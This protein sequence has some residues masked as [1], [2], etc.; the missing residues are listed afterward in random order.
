M[1]PEILA[2]H[3]TRGGMI[4][5][6]GD[7][8]RFYIKGPRAWHMDTNP[9]AYTARKLRGAIGPDTAEISA[10]LQRLGFH[11]EDLGEGRMAWHLSR[12]RAYWRVTD[13]HGGLPSHWDAATM[14]RTGAGSFEH[15]TCFGSTR[16]CIDAIAA[17]LADFDGPSRDRGNA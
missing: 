6:L 15:L 5:G 11:R 14:W 3:V 10:T 12:G 13:D 2:Q 4:W 7:D 1:K 9:P 8:G 16:N 17:R